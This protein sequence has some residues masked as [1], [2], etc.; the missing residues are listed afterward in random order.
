MSK[1]PLKALGVKKTHK[2]FRCTVRAVDNQ[3]LRLFFCA[4]KK[5][6]PAFA[7]TDDYKISEKQFTPFHPVPIVPV[8]DFQIIIDVIVRVFYVS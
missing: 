7:A 3:A 5:C 6:F 4:G 2:S 8:E 1:N